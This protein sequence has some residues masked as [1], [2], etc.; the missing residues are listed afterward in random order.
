MK[1][2]IVILALAVLLM[3]AASGC[4][5]GGELFGAG[6][7]TGAVGSGTLAGMGKDLNLV[8]QNLQEQYAKAV[9]DNASP[10]VLERLELSI[11]RVQDAKAATVT[12]QDL[13]VKSRD[14]DWTDP[15]AVGGYAGFAI[16]SILGLFTKRK[17]DIV[18]GKYESHKDGVDKTIRE[19]GSTKIGETLYA[20]IGEARLKNGVH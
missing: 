12:G 4:S 2:K 6:V 17:K 7:A 20:N 14:V 1:N 15:T 3:I 11:R 19:S 9:A 13:I 8:E 16:A 10:A 18:T 5:G